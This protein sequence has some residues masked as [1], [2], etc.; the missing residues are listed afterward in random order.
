MK[1]K[2]HVRIDGRRT[3]F[4][5]EDEFWI[6]LTEIASSLK[7]T[8]IDLIRLTAKTS[9][10]G[11]LVSDLRTFVLRHY[12]GRAKSHAGQISR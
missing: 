9:L 10:R 12:Q 5:I 11:S 2:R 7:T 1:R 4:S 6:A 3:T 8:R